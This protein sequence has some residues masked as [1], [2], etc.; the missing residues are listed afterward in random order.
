VA[1]T[2]EA[3]DGLLAMPAPADGVDRIGRGC[4]PGG[5]PDDDFADAIPV[6]GLVVFTSPVP[7]LDLPRSAPGAF[8]GETDA[9]RL[10][11]FSTREDI[12]RGPP[13]LT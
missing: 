6:S 12:E 5:N 9:P 2:H 4:P 7:G 10:R 8:V 11:I 1:N 3:L 13:S